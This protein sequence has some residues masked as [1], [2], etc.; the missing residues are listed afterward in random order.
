MTPEIDNVG[1]AI[2]KGAYNPEAKDFMVDLSQF[3]LRALLGDDVLKEVP[4][5]KGVVALFK[6]PLAIRDQLFLRKVAGF[7]AACPRFTDTE[8]EAF[9]REHLNDPQK[10]NKLGESLVLILDRLDDLEKPQMLAKMFA[11]F[12]Q[13]K[14]GFDIFRRLAKAIDAGS[15]ED[16]REFAK[17]K[18]IPE[19]PSRTQDNQT[20]ILHTNLVR[21]GL[22]GLPHYSGTV[23]ILG[24]AFVVNELGKT[25]QMC[26]NA[27]PTT[28]S[29]QN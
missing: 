20:R 10:S 15:I 2:L 26:M 19:G 1:V 23:P 27:S 7:F 29:L 25:F 18:A 4:F 5:I 12:V 13:G 3:E 8:K 9:V 17:I 24:V 11:A 14:I 22:V 6:I 28:P 21:T 16:L